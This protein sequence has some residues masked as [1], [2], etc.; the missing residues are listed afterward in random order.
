[1]IFITGDTHG[2]IDAKKIVDLALKQQLTNSD[3]VIIAGDF[4]AIWDY[5]SIDKCVEFY[6]QLPFTTLFVDGNHEN[7]DFL[8]SFPLEQWNGGKIHRVSSKIIHLM[9]GEVFLI[10]GLKILTIGGAESDDKDYRTAHVSWW[11]QE[12]I[13]LEDVNHAILSSSQFDQIDCIISHT[14]PQKIITKE[15][16]NRRPNKTIFTSEELLNIIYEKIPYAKW[17]FG[18]WHIDMDITDRVRA[19]YNDIIKL[20]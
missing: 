13:A 17:Y 3:Y 16:T 2:F 6:N 14:C 15:L 8:L 20:R 10:D 9:R 12:S 4:G 11:P 1:M 18:H 5:R 7:F 19:V